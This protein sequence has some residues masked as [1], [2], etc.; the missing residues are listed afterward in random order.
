MSFGLTLAVGSVLATVILGADVWSAFLEAANLASG[1]LGEG[2]YP[3]T[4]M[5]SIYAMFRSIGVSSE[6]A[7]YI[8]I[9]VAL[10]ALFSIFWVSKHGRSVSEMQAVAILAGLMVTPYAYDYDLSI[11]VLALLLVAPALARLGSLR[12]VF[13]TSLWWF[14]PGY[15]LFILFG[16]QFGGADQD[17]YASLSV[18]APFV[19][20]AS[21]F[22]MWFARLESSKAEQIQ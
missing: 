9:V 8:Q 22:S 18:G 10:V 20:A 4:R 12:Y 19:L 7:L 21:F 17:H 16:I 13:L 2:Y 6:A 5:F 14:P 15:N 1:F 3:L 11:A